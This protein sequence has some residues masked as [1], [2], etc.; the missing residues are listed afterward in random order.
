MR[1]FSFN[2]RAAGRE[3]DAGGTASGCARLGL[4]APAGVGSCSCALRFRLQGVADA[5][6]AR[7]GL[8]AFWLGRLA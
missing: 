8:R 6:C 5:D 7:H 1:F 4:T 2:G 3:A